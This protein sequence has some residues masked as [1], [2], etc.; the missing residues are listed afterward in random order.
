M[1]TL[2]LIMLNAIN[3]TL[4]ESSACSAKAR[5]YMK[6]RE[7][8]APETTE[9]TA[10]PDKIQKKTPTLIPPPITLIAA[11]F[12]DSKSSVFLTTGEQVR[13]IKIPTGIDPSNICW[14]CIWLILSIIIGISRA[15]NSFQNSGLSMET[16][17]HARGSNQLKDK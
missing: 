2:R 17:N 12:I 1:T 9:K 16:K 7:E 5:A 10:F 11:L 3:L 15:I 4:M 13:C 6:P 14:M 8:N